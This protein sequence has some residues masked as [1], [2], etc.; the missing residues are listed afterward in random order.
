MKKILVLIVFISI[1]FC[2]KAQW[3]KP[4]HK[5]FDTVEYVV[6][7]DLKFKEDTIHLNYCQTE[8]QMLSIGSSRKITSYRAYNS[9]KLDMELKRRGED[10]TSLDW[11]QSANFSMDYVATHLFDIFK[12]YDKG[13]I[14][15]ND[16]IF[17]M[18]LYEYEEPFDSFNWQ[19]TAETD[20][21]SDYICQKAIC[22]FG[23][24][25][26]LAWF[27]TEIPISDGPY[28]FC[29]LPGLILNIADT[30]NHYSFE[31]VSIEEPSELMMVY[32]VI[33]DRVPTTKKEFFRQ[34]D[35][36][37]NNISHGVKEM[38]SNE[39]AV[40]KAVEYEMSKN[41]PIELDR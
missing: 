8:K 2:V 16:H 39:K 31:F 10:G 3:W 4:Q 7:Y 13:I 1:G 28:K 32:D 41:N 27:T 6:M 5:E 22:Y 12:D 17:Q 34:Q 40:Q 29:G 36:L 23:G 15:T 21:I 20:T 38:T 26:W 14:T 33:K 9:Y 18:G 25:T 19:I 30:E 37:K 24:R 11:I 35:R